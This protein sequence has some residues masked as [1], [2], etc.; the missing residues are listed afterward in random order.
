MRRFGTSLAALGLAV[1]GLVAP[2]AVAEA[3]ATGT[4]SNHCNDIWPGR[5]GY[6]YAYDGAYCYT[7]L[8][9]AAGDDA[10]WNAAG[11]GFENAG[12]KASS[13][14]NAGYTGSYS[15]VQFHYLTG[16]AG[17]YNCLKAEEFFVDDLSR[18]TFSSGYTM[19]N[20]IRS[21]RWVNGCDRWMS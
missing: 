6:V 5:N 7:Q 3:S 1:A 9:R 4:A 20:N 12:D 16:Y 14:L 15:I 2:A 21:H 8:G 19:N 10:D 11:G 17:G 13:V 18:N